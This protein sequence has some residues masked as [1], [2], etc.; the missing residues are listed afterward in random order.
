MKNDFDTRLKNI[1]EE[2]L[3]LKTASEYSSVR[4]S[5]ITSASRIR[6]GLYRVNYDTNGQA[7]LSTF[8]KEIDSGYCEIYG[9]TPTSNSQVVEVVTTTW[10]NEEQR[11]ITYENGLVVVSNVPVASI[12]RIS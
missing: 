12:T 3:A 2:L 9:R 4:N 11:Y 8:Y 5:S 7:I 6:T 1:E 10:S